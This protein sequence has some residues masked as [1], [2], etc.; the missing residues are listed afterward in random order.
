MWILQWHVKRTIRI[1]F[2][3]NLPLF[4]SQYNLVCQNIMTRYRYFRT[5]LTIPISTNIFLGVFLKPRA[6][7]CPHTLAEAEAKSTAV[8]KLDSKCSDLYN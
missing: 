3:D 6:A 2:W 1:E 8:L 7:K 5:F 4:Q